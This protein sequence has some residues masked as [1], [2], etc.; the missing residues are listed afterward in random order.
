M[1]E[2]TGAGG[3]FLA[4]AADDL[5]FSLAGGP[6][7][8]FPF[9]HLGKVDYGHWHGEKLPSFGSAQKRNV[10]PHRICPKGA[11]ASSPAVARN[12]LPWVL[13]QQN[14][15]TATRLRPFRFRTARVPVEPQPSLG[16]FPFSNVT[17]GS[18][19]LATLG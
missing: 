18:S 17:Q 3:N 19:Y 10:V 2:F 8:A 5:G 1:G 6:G 16:L 15:P 13:V 7:G 11:V 9:A 12:E 4:D 14:I